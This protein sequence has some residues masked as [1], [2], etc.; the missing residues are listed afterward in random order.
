VS[1]FKGARRVAAALAGAAVAMTFATAHAAVA[2]VSLQKVSSDP[3]TNTSSYHKTQV[4]PD[5]FAWGN[6]IIGV[7]QTGRFYDGGSSDPGWAT[8]TDGGGTWT[9]GFLPGLTTYSNPP[10]PYDRATDPSIAYDPKHDVW[11]AQTLGMFGSTGAAVVVNRS[12]DGGLTWSNPVTILAQTGADKNWIVCDTWAA[13]PFYGNCYAEWDD[14]FSGN[15]LFMSTSTDGGK[16]WK[17]AS[18]PG[19]SVIGGQPV[20]QPNGKIGRAHV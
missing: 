3:F 4:E 11:L 13:S 18:S 10:G 20:V 16:T 2:N 17:T 1:L 9:H 6:T 5:T 15:T 7:F 8:S 12:T 14:N 19:A